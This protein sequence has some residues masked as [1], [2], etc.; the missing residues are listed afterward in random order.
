MVLR[1]AK[2]S[3]VRFALETAVNIVLYMLHSVVSGV[4][5]KH[6]EEGIR[7]RRIC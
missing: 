7:Y 5:F 1:D 2:W 4:I 6:G 3:P